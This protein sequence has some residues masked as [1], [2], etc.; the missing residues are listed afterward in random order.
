[1]ETILRAAEDVELIGPWVLGE[2]VCQRI[3]EACPNIVVI[4]DEESQNEA[5]ARLTASVLEQYPDLSVIY[6]GLNENVFRVFSTHTLPARGAD[7][8]ETIRNLP[9]MDF[10]GNSSQSK[11]KSS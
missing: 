11:I 3:G 10:D 1:M 6:T 7:L 4:A 5:V 2:D 9:P 8:L